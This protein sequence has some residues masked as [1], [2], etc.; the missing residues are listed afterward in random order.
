MMIM[1]IVIDHD[2][3]NNDD[4]G[5]HWWLW[6]LMVTKMPFC[7][8]DNHFMPYLEFSFWQELLR[9]Q[10]TQD[11]IPALESKLFF[12]FQFYKPCLGY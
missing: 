6:W 10:Y 8:L 9:L 5:Y 1:M 7:E 11:Q 12:S 3:D 4:Y 2:H